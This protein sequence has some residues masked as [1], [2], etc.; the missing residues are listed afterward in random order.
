MTVFNLSDA[1][2]AT[3]RR[4]VDVCIVGGGM[5]GLAT[6]QRLSAVAGV[7]IC[8]LESGAHA[9]DEGLEALNDIEDC[10]GRYA[11]A[12]DSRV[13][14]IGG[15]SSLWGGRLLPLTAHDLGAREYASI[16]AWPIRPEELDAHTASVET[17][18]DLDHRP[19]ELTDLTRLWPKF[20]IYP[21]HADV[22]CRFAKFPT[23]R[24][25]NIATA[26]RRSVLAGARAAVYLNATAHD[27]ALDAE[28]GQVREVVARA[29]GGASLRVTARYFIFSAGTIETTRLTLLLNR[30][31]GERAFAGCTALG[32]YFND[33]LKVPVGTVYPV[34][35]RATNRLFGYHLA[36]ST[37][38]NL[39]FELSAQA[40]RQLAIPSA[41]IDFRL[42]MPDRSIYR[43][44]RDLGGR[45]QG[46]NMPHRNLQVL[47]EALDV[48][49]LYRLL[50]WR[51]RHRQLYLS[52]EIG[53]TAEMR[54]EQSPSA[55]H[56]VALSDRADAYGVPLVR[57]TWAPTDADRRT[58]LAA[59][60][61]FKT[62]WSQA[63]LA[64]SSPIA[65]E[66]D[67][68]AAGD[69]FLE[70]ARDASHPAGSTRMGIDP[71]RSV[72]DATLRC[73]AVKNLFLVSASVFPG[74][75]SANP[76]LTI[77]Q[78][79]HRCADHIV[80]ELRVA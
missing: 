10:A 42:G 9:R 30:I 59:L 49:T 64:S 22:S 17:L 11:G 53:I 32:H 43:A 29:P 35:I 48:D 79:A 80:R 25:R 75:G 40:Q 4:E 70:A 16:D 27:F 51:L 57:L 71:T 60:R 3:L 73:H 50:F 77:L 76:T 8:V 68:E 55:A 2:S 62:F 69:R 21:R 38:R 44:L 5:A 15:A 19:F 12:R 56:R 14:L 58:F 7:R 23:F 45:L 36:G 37:R 66:A 34:D 47:R 54:I 65:W 28:T 6:A 46:R 61:H 41:Y 74:A 18:F 24:N 52:A 20:G 72:V 26:L 33:H 78:L 1:N 67:D 31:S 13:R 39:H 63:G